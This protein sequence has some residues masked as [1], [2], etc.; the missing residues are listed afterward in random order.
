MT[1]PTRTIKIYEKTHPTLRLLAAMTG[2]TM[3]DLVDR[4]VRE[5][6]ER[7]AAGKEEWEVVDGLNQ[8]IR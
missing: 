5:E 6:K 2:E 3:M 4:L 1:E 8:R 7:I